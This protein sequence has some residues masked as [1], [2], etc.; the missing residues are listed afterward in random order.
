MTTSVFERLS[1]QGTAASNARVAQEKQWREQQKQQH[2][3]DAAALT[4]IT[5]PAK[6]EQLKIP[7]DH[8]AGLIKS[9]RR[10]PKQRDEY[11]SR[12]AKQETVCSAG[13][14]IPDAHEDADYVQIQSPKKATGH[15]GHSAV[16]NRLYKQETAASMAHHY[17]KEEKTPPPLSPRK[18]NPSPPPSLLKRLEQKS[19]SVPPTPITMN[20]HIRTKEEKKG[21]K[22][23]NNL[24]I[25][26]ANVRKQINLFHTGKISARAL[27]CDVINALFERDF[28]PGAHWDIGSAHA[29]EMDPLTDKTL[30]DGGEEGDKMECFQAD[31]EAI[32][33]W[34]DIYSVATAKATIKISS[35][36][37]YV[38][39]YSYYVAG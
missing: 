26:Q 24:N 28:M 32:W 34:K 18:A 29:E 1:S 37:V 3:A 35:D 36:H 33:D 4:P 17:V 2:A 14:H 27:A 31:K 9:P 22:S 25:S 21:G 30:L 11:L 8:Q 12:L 6:L 13:H 38:D 5:N 23:Y 7:Q 20:L 16:F 39:E 15:S 19:E 10:T